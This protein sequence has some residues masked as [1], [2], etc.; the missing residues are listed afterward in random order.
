MGKPSVV[1]VSDIEAKG[2]IAPD[3][4]STCYLLSAG[5]DGEAEKA[6]LRLYEPREQRI[7]LWYDNTGHLPYCISKRPK[8]ELERIEELVKHP[9]FLRLEEIKRYDALRD[10][11][12]KVT[13]VVASNPLAIGGQGKN[14]IRHIL[15]ESWESHIRYYQNYI[16]DNALIPGMPYRIVDGKLVEDYRLPEDVKRRLGE[17]LKEVEPE[18]R[19]KMLEWVR[20]LECP[21]P[22]IRRAAIDI[23]VGG[24]VAERVPNPEKA[25][26]PIIAISIVSSDGVRRVL[27][28]GERHG[29]LEVD[30]AE[31]ELMPEEE[32]IR[33]A[34]KV[35]DEYPVILTFNGDDFDLRYLRNRA[36]RLGFPREAIPISIGRRFASLRYG[37]HIDL[38]RFFQN[39]SIQVYAFGD[40]YRENTLDEVASTILGKGKIEV[41]EISKLT[42]R[43]LAR[44]G[45]QKSLV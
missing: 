7:Y 1:G 11:W 37:L 19:E 21:I 26:D 32:L 43:E 22:K 35:L 4:L 23:E 25:E 24:A 27:L 5:Y 17:L 36:K 39:K 15:G 3:N 18:F 2:R 30:G 42:E 41:T 12:I 40:R 31:V 38:Y 13:K 45:S 8:E 29:R 14:D 9:G 20:L 28:R 16:Y 10:K 44:Y 6:F 33:E 34:F